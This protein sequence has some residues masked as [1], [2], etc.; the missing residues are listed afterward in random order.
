MEMVSRWPFTLARDPFLLWPDPFNLWLY[1]S[2]F[3]HIACSFWKLTYI[4]RLGL[5][6]TGGRW[7]QVF[8]FYD[9]WCI[10]V[11]DR[12]CHPIKENVY[13]GI[14]DH[15]LLVKLINIFSFF[16]SFLLFLAMRPFQWYF[17]LF[18]SKATSYKT[19]SRFTAA[20]P[21]ILVRK[22]RWLATRLT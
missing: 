4:L 17:F 7:C 9:K 20:F 3:A 11:I 10:R 15:L 8:M 13:L 6:R 12:N 22:K 16:F 5:S 21:Y 18:Q 19:Q 1:G 2:I 14:S